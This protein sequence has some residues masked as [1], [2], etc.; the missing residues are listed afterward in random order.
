MGFIQRFF[1]ILIIRSELALSL[2]LGLEYFSKYTKLP[3][4]WRSM[5]VAWFAPELKKID[6]SQMNSH[7]PVNDINF[8]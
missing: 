3:E 1:I 2:M 6:R 5:D 8:C 4:N 7:R